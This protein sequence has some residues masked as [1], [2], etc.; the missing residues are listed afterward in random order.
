M[1]PR[2]KS[3]YT[4]VVHLRYKNATANMPLGS[5]R[6]SNAL[7]SQKPRGEANRPFIRARPSVHPLRKSGL[8]LPN[9]DEP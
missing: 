4:E 9:L 1:S 5:S 7:P 3:E 6:S 8:P 2:S